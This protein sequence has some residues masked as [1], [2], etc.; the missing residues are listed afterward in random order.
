MSGHPHDRFGSKVTSLRFSAAEMDS[1][2]ESV[3][4]EFGD[5]S[6]DEFEKQFRRKMRIRA[7]RKLSMFAGE[8]FEVPLATGRKYAQETWVA[9]EDHDG[10]VS[11]HLKAD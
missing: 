1:M 9:T 8:G 2:W 10:G 4:E 7:M 3:M 5:Q 11:L 6:N